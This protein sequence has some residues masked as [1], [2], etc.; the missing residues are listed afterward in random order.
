MWFAKVIKNLK[1]WDISLMK[2]GVFFFTF[3][4]ASYISSNTLIGGRW[5]WLILAI[6][7]SI[8]PVS[9]AIKHM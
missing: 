6:L 2:L 9:I 3:F 5:I 4:I 7:F 8:K 1:W